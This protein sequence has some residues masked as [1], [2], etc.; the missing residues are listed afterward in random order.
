MGCAKDS[1]AL[2]EEALC[3]MLFSIEEH[4]QLDKVR[5]RA[6]HPAFMKM[7]YNNKLLLSDIA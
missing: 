7:E 6:G 1:E 3:S 4:L 2:K 5:L